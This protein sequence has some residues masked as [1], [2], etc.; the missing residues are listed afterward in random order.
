M[1]VCAGAW[2]INSLRA[3]AQN[4]VTTTTPLTRQALSTPTSYFTARKHSDLMYMHSVECNE[5]FMSLSKRTDH[6]DIK[7]TV[8]S[9]A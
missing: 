8:K 6:G 4:V 5:W 2:Q 1:C 9:P 7:V 3:P